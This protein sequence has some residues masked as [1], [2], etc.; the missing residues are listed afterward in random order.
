[1]SDRYGTRNILL[2]S[3]MLTMVATVLMPAAAIHLP[4][5]AAWCLR[6][7][8]GVAF[9]FNMPCA[10]SAVSRWFPKSERGTVNMIW[11]LGE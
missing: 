8:V 3:A 5:G 2:F 1:L 11:M 4:Y 7:L 9:G 10:L 6:A